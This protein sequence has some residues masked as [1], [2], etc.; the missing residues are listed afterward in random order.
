ML[1][2]NK[3]SREET[4]PA[5]GN[6]ILL[7]DNDN[8]QGD[9]GEETDE[10]QQQELELLS[11]RAMAARSGAITASVP[12]KCPYLDTV[13][14]AVLD[15]DMTAACSVTL[16]R[17]HVYACLVCGRF[18]Q[19]RGVNTPAY[20]HALQAGHFVYMR[21]EDGAVYCLPDGYLVHDSSLDDIKRCLLPT[22]TTEELATLSSSNTTLARDVHGVSYLPGYMGINNLTQTDGF[23]CALHVLAH[24]K[25]IRD[26]YLSPTTPA[27]T[28]SLSMQ[29]RRTLRRMWSRHN[30]KSVVSPQELM[31]EVTVASEGRF[32][33]GKKVIHVVV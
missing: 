26:Y 21:L 5:T 32:A 11:P 4:I 17:L 27:P 16:S 22:F 9:F 3:R 15:F 1:S 33:I 31:Y 20:T 2:G 6:E 7:E 19:G 13:N 30:F 25:H 23:N 8:E 29:F 10:G 18:F 24:M 14:R 12:R 28:S